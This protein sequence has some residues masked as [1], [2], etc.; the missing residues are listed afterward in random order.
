[1]LHKKI[2]EKMQSAY[3]YH[4]IANPSH[5][6]KVGSKALNFSVD[7]RNNLQAEA[8]I[9]RCALGEEDEQENGPRPRREDYRRT[10]VKRE[11]EERDQL[12]QWAVNNTN[13]AD[14]DAGHHDHHTAL[15]TLELTTR[16]CD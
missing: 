4:V 5:K 3:S 13:D 16:K 8:N 15:I 14:G 6:R 10:R 7:I 9:C 11:E 2:K 12:S 1:M